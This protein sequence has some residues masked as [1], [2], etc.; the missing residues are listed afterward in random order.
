MLLARSS[1]LNFLAV[2][3]IDDDDDDGALKFHRKNLSSFCVS[4][5]N[6]PLNVS[7]V[8]NSTLLNIVYGRRIGALSALPLSAFT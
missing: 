3:F 5:L 7:H 2:A 8:V 4:S 6:Q 1:K